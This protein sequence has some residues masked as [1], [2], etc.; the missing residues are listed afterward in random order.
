MR[1]RGVSPILCRM[2]GRTVGVTDL[3]EREGGTLSAHWLFLLVTAGVMQ[4]HTGCHLLLSFIWKQ[5]L[6]CQLSR[7]SYLSKLVFTSLNKL[8]NKAIGAR[9]LL[10]VSCSW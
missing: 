6:S 4:Y 1:T 10:L 9:K 5:E 8:N 2:L 3:E 7:L